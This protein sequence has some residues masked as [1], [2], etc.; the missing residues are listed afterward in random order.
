[1]EA[2]KLHAVEME[3]KGLEIAASSADEGRPQSST[4][5]TSPAESMAMAE[6][7]TSRR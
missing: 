2:T 5:L 7:R 1:M 3:K 6:A 4:P